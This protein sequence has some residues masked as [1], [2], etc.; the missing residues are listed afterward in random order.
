MVVMIIQYGKNAYVIAYLWQ[1]V[2]TKSVSPYWINDYAT[3][4]NA[5]KDVSS[6]TYIWDSYPLIGVAYSTF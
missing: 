2:Y 3:N 6:F 5:W 1:L 4:Y